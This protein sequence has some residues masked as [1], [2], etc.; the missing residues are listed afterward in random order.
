MK[1]CDENIQAVLELSKEMIDH[2]IKGINE[3]ED[4]DCAI[5]YGIVL[6]SAYKIRTVAKAEKEKHIQKGWWE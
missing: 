6:D 3:R 5:L 2:A 1:P 4:D